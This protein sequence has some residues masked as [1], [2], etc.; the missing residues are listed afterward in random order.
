[1]RV[2]GIGGSVHDFGACLLEDGRIVTAI[3]DERITRQKYGMGTVSAMGFSSRY[4]LQRAGITAADVDMFV[5]ND[6]TMHTAYSIAKNKIQIIGHHLA[7]AASAFYASPFDQAAI[8]IID[9]EGSKFRDPATGTVY[10]ET[11]TYAIG[12]GNQIQICDT[13]YGSTW[14]LL[15]TPCNHK[16]CILKGPETHQWIYD[17]Y[18][19]QTGQEPEKPIRPFCLAD[20]IINNS[21]G[22]LY[23]YVTRLAGMGC[24]DAGKT[25]GL[26]AYGTDSLLPCLRSFIHLGSEGQIKIELSQSFI[27]EFLSDTNRLTGKELFQKRAD[28]AWAA[29]HILEEVFFYCADH[30]YQTTGLKNLCIAGGCAL[31]CQANGRLLKRGPFDN[32][33][34]QPAGADNGTAIGAALYGYYGIHNAPRDNPYNGGMHHTFLGASYNCGSIQRALA[35]CNGIIWQEVSNI[36]ETAAKALSESKIVGWFQGGSEYGPRAL[37]HRSILADPRCPGMKDILNNQVKHRESFRP[38]APSVLE[39][40]AGKYFDINRSSPFML[41]TVLAKKPEEIPAVVHVDGTSRLHTVDR[42]TNPGFYTLISAFNDLTGVPVLLNTS[43]NIKGEP[44]VESPDDALRTFINSQM[45]ALAI[46]D[47]WITKEKSRKG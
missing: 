37:G 42:K 6:S 13:I 30:L 20:K 35:R 39:E 27:E 29:Q 14:V 18:I 26:A 16:T 10:S 5:S 32:I 15:Q 17:S 38:F 23:L 45:D 2:L 9:N 7:H 31:N 41:F 46:G 21:L 25:M 43:F 11:I 4:C 34:I 36:F 12:R 40:F 24:M 22:G 28:L 47:I 33:Y 8:L 44:I 3:E 19:E 1:M